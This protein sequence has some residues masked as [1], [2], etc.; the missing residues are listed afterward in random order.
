MA[1]NL[2]NTDIYDITSTV[3]ELQQR[4][5]P[6]ESASTL[7]MGIYGYLAEFHA[8]ALQN[9]I[10]VASELGN[11]LFPWRAKFERNI[12]SHSI[13]QGIT[14][15]N[16][17][18][19]VLEILLCIK[20]EDVEKYSINNVFTLDKESS[21]DIDGIEFHLPYDLNIKKNYI[22]NEEVVYSGVYDMS[23][24]NPLCNIVN[25]YITTPFIQEDNL[26]KLLC[27]PCTLLQVSHEIHYNKLMTSSIIENKTYEFDFENQL[28]DF[29]VKV[30]ENDKVTYLTPIFEGSALED[31]LEHFCY[32]SYLDSN[33]IRV[34]FDSIS[35]LPGINAE[36]ETL[37]KTTIGKDGEFEYVNK[38]ITDVIKSNRFN[39]N[40]LS[41]LIRL[42][43]DSE[44]G[45]DRKSID[46]LKRLLPKE[47]VSRGS[48]SK[49]TDLQ[50]YFN[51][52][53]TDTN[54]I[55]VSGRV[56]NQFE[57]SYYT[58]LVMK[59]ELDNIIPSN[60]ID[61]TLRR[62][63]FLNND[64]GIYTLKPG[65]CILYNENGRSTVVDPESD[66]IQELINNERD[67]T[68]FLYTIPYN[69]N[70]STKPLYASYY[71]TVFDHDAYLEFTKINENSP[72]QF[73]STFINWSRNY[74]EDVDTY[75]LTLTLTQNIN[76]N[77]G[78]IQIDD[79]GK[80]TTNNLKIAMVIYNT[81]TTG[82]NIPYRYV[83][84]KLIDYDNL[85]YSYT[86]E[87]ELYTN[88]EFDSDRRLKIL[89]TLVP[90]NSNTGTGGSDTE[91]YGFF[92][93]DVKVELYTLYKSNE[94]IGISSDY[95]INSIDPKLS[96]EG[97]ITTNMYTVNGGLFF[98]KNYTDTITSTVNQATVKE[99]EES[100]YGFKIYSV[101][102]F[103]Y[104]YMM[105]SERA[106][107]VFNQI[108]YNRSYVESATDYLENN[109][110]IDFKLFNTYGPSHIYST[111]KYGKNIIDRTNLSI[112]FIMSLTS[113]ADAN[114]KEYIIKDIKN[115]I[116]DIN[117]IGN[118]HIPNIITTITTSYRNSLQYFEFLGFNDYGPTVQ[119]LYHNDPDQIFVVPEL[120]V[121]HTL[122][123][124]EP[125]IIIDI[126]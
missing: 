44:G 17:V 79:A 91:T 93:E 113:T 56:D 69:I 2:I 21:Y 117:N 32:Y 122:I 97:Y 96:E 37:V 31:D 63:E 50:N 94:T 89:N 100:E 77:K 71:L 62:S 48:I 90:Y 25:P 99:N 16:A 39:Y 124:G 14:D 105:D 23:R 82:D 112:H 4:Y 106:S 36:I 121:A 13:I 104:T 54:N 78:V 58:Y 64:H 110:I 35:Y 40:T 83:Y 42:R 72:L 7:S 9:S 18:P 108:D 88:N 3:N 49:T 87:F 86:Y 76:S 10:I 51:M 119:H 123:S 52:I 114:I 120:L 98:Y 67:K 107:Y 68:T 28:A 95:I 59:D 55:V 84:G 65:T 11:E 30:T 60:T 101:P 109:F 27:I 80:I 66:E 116:E 111:D 29:E 125:D 92:D 115:I 81:N 43:S 73:I 5:I 57:R 20:L 6:E 61:I 126:A 103:R 33:T 34:R 75:R 47:T 46:E 1:D 41:V 38:Y 26:V 8:Q 85:T 24:N 74:N 70:I 102:V 45:L 118:I 22:S 53:N 15:I 12:I 19:S